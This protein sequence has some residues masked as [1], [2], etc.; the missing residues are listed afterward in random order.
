MEDKMECILIGP[1]VIVMC[2]VICV[3]LIAMITM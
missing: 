3:A 2:V 1:V